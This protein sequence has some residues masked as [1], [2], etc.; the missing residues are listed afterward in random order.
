MSTPGHYPADLAPASTAV[1]QRIQRVV[2]RTPRPERIRVVESENS[3][4][5]SD[6]RGSAPP[7]P[8][9]RSC[10]Q[11]RQYLGSSRMLDGVRASVSL[12]AGPRGRLRYVSTAVPSAV[13]QVEHAA[14]AQFVPDSRHRQRHSRSCAR[15][16]AASRFSRARYAAS[17]VS[18]VMWRRSAVSCS[19]GVVAPL[20]DMPCRALRSGCHRSPTLCP[21]HHRARCRCGFRTERGVFAPAIRRGSR[22][23]G[24][25]PSSLLCPRQ[26]APYRASSATVASGVRMRPPGVRHCRDDAEPSQVP[27]KV[28]R[29]RA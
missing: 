29:T 19:P 7:R 1:R 22:P 27:T 18:V 15:N 24:S 23:L 11:P 17:S 14:R 13:L 3:D 4:R 6:G 20:Q 28:L 10:P 25:P 26:T 12:P 21:I 8:A 9:G 2:R 5:R 16:R